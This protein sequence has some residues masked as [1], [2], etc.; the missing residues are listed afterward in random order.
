MTA[1]K[2]PARKTARP[3]HR[4]EPSQD[5]AFPLSS[6]APR[7]GLTLLPSPVASKHAAVVQH[8]GSCREER[9][10][11]ES[12]PAV[13]GMELITMLLEDSLEASP[14]LARKAIDKL[15]ATF[16]GVDPGGLAGSPEVSQLAALL[17]S[18]LDVK[19]GAE[20]V[21]PAVALQALLG[22]SL[23]EGSLTGLL[24]MVKTLLFSQVSWVG[25]DCGGRGQG[26]V[27]GGCDCCRSVTPRNNTAMPC[28]SAD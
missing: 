10:A 28:C 3:I 9:P 26:M 13:W 18:V 5:F 6:H 2:N 27:S 22:I 8:R 19:A 23:A 20:V 17:S 21:E 11:L 7:S 4:H 15:V 12:G 25:I 24:G 14:G 16:D 1:A